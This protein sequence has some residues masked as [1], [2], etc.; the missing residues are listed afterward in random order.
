MY[1]RSIIFTIFL[2]MVVQNLN[3][4]LK[5]NVIPQDAQCS[6]TGFFSSGVFFFYDFFVV[7]TYHS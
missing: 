2:D 5:K 3:S 1:G 6:E 7:C 4:W